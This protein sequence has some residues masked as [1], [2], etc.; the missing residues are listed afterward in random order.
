MEHPGNLEQ[1]AIDRLDMALLRSSFLDEFAQIEASIGRILCSS[2][3][4]QSGE[5]F[6][7]RLKEFRKVEKTPMIAKA[8]LNQRDPIADSI[9]AILTTRADIV[10]SSMRIG[11]V[12]GQSTAMFTNAKE[13]ITDYPCSRLLST[14]AFRELIYTAQCINKRIAALGRVNP[15]SVPQPP[16][17]DAAGGP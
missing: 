2:G 7:Q 14:T 13:S 3:V 6:S 17:P 4:V 5:P 12:D 11:V 16:S 15:A 1:S 8:N 10:H 9:A